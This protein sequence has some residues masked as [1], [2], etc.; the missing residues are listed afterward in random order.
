MEEQKKTNNNNPKHKSLTRAWK[1]IFLAPTTVSLWF[2]L[3][4]VLFKVALHFAT[5]QWYFQHSVR[6]QPSQMRLFS[7][8]QFRSIHNVFPLLC[9]YTRIPRCA[10]SNSLPVFIMMSLV[11][12]QRSCR[13]I[14][15]IFLTFFKFFFPLS[16]PHFTKFHVFNVFENIKTQIQH[17]AADGQTEAKDVT[18]RSRSETHRLS[19]TGAP[20]LHSLHFAHV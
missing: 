11:L 3:S 7:M 20:P 4:L 8:I 1:R 16:A 15:N 9:N 18:S 12:P 5:L 10:I 17:C 13:G 6:Q 19:D 14:V 2:Y